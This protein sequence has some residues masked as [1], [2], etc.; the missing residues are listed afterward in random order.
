[1]RLRGD[2]ANEAGVKVLE[3]GESADTIFLGRLH[4]GAGG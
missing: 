3:E 2:W 1:M 4:R